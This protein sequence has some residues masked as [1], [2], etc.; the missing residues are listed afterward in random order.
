MK[1]YGAFKMVVKMLLMLNSKIDVDGCGNMDVATSVLE[2]RNLVVLKVIIKLLSYN[3]NS[4]FFSA[5][6]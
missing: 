2:V 3:L 4:D 5:W 6:L 1:V